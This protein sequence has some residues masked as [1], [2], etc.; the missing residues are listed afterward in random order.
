MS[1]SME[2][3]TD[4]AALGAAVIPLI[5]NVLAALL[6][7]IIGKWVARQFVNLAQKGMTRSRMDPT[8]VPFLGNVIYGIALAVILIS[9]LG[10]LGIDTTSAAA[11]LGGA[12]IAIGLSLQ[13]QLSSFAAGVMLIMFRPFKVGDFVQAGGVMGTVELIKI[14]HTILKSPDN[15]E[16][17][18][19]NAQVWGSTITNFSARPTRRVD[20]LIG[21]SYNADLRKAKATLERIMKEEARLLEDPAWSV[22]VTALN[23]SSVD[24]A[25]RG[26][27]NSGDWW[28]TRCD[29]IERI[30]LTFDD[31]GIEIPFPQMDVH[32]R[33]MPEA[34]AA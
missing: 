27:T 28:A 25:V 12:A 11:V 33:D 29:L 17:T 16:I 5:I 34:K 32:V 20:L 13:N 14:T 4:P 10:R 19:P 30:K 21:I 9:A 2:T 22:V 18:V 1:V 8:L 6:I 23:D 7:F 24:F 15:Q 31:E 26:W 3:L